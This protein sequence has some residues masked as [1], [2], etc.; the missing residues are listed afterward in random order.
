MFKTDVVNSKN[1]RKTTGYKIVQI[2]LIP[3]LLFFFSLSLNLFGS[4]S[5]IQ[6]FFR[7]ENSQ[8]F[9]QLSILIVLGVLIFSMI[10]RARLKNPAKL[11]SVEIDDNGLKF[12]DNDHSE[13]TYR[14]SELDKVSFEFF[15]TSNSANPRG[16]LNYFTLL[17]NQ[18]KNTF[19]I[20][21]DNSLTKAEIG[22]LLRE[23][24]K[25]VPVKIKYRALYKIIFG[26]NDFK[27]S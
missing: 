20:L 22:E 24:N 23:I 12:I 3:F 11:G 13:Q 1:I 21:I 14:W 15:S 18:N 9:R 4:D 27:L 8:A 17:K 6:T 7:G 25:K 26:D 16:C 19:E 10:V 5:A 2:I